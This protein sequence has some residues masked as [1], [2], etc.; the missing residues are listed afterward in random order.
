MSFSFHLRFELWLTWASHGGIHHIHLRS[1]STGKE[2]GLASK[3]Q[4]LHPVE[5]TTATIVM[6]SYAVQVN[7][8][9]LGVAFTCEDD[10][11]DN[12]VVVWNWKTGDRLFVSGRL[13]LG[14]GHFEH[15]YPLLLTSFTIISRR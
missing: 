2:H 10:E 12:D 13:R 6:W 8:D 14:S 15:L 9:Y 11:V 1:L 5:F 3:E 4:L 7:G